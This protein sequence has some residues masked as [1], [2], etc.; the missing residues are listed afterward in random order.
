MITSC[1]VLQDNAMTNTIVSKRKEVYKKNQRWHMKCIKNLQIFINQTLHRVWFE[2]C[3]NYFSLDFIF[4]FSLIFLGHE[5][6]TWLLSGLY[7]VTL[8]FT[9]LLKTWWLIFK[10]KF[11][12]C[13][14]VNVCWC[15]MSVRV[16]LC[17]W[18]CCLFKIKAANYILKE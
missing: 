5:I 9:N 10:A 2:V 12:S 16:P 17:L 11:A 7:L 1:W 3:S 4:I 18:S 6:D 13:T 8:H 14:R 15:W